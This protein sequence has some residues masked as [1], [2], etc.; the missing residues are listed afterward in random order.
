MP[1]SALGRLYSTPPGIIGPPR[2]PNCRCQIVAAP[3]GE[4]GNR[5]G[6]A[7]RREAER[8]IARGWAL[9]SEPESV[10]LRAADAL[11]RR[12]NRLPRSV[13]AAAVAAVEDGSIRR[14]FPG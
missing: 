9:D 5:Y 6:E 13:N 14:P 3:M 12:P 1:S 10:R 2:H 7:L 8:S 4:A 11:T